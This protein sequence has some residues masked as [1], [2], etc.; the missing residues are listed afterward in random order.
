MISWRTIARTKG[1][2]N[3]ESK[4]E[5]KRKWRESGGV[6]EPFQQAKRRYDILSMNQAS[7]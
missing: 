2:W 7:A 6:D 5:K 3:G 1:K 4:K